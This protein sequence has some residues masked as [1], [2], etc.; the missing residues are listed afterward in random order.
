VGNNLLLSIFALIFLGC[1]PKLRVQ[2]IAY[3]EQLERKYYKLSK[4]SVNYNNII[5]TSAVYIL[6]RDWTIDGKPEIKRLFCFIRFGAD[7]VAFFSNFYSRPINYEEFVGMPDGEFCF[8]QLS[9]NQ[10][11]MERYDFH[12]KLFKYWYGEFNQNKIVFTHYK[13]RTLGG[14]RGSLGNLI[15]EKSKLK[16]P[17]KVVFPSPSSR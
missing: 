11:K 2:S 17:N 13:L 16:I 14:A 6:E 4:T 1:H 12:L 7:G 10:I 15:F 3:P 5:D 8:Y 9:G